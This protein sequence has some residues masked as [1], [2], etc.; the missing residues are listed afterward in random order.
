M[1]ALLPH[2]A[3]AATQAVREEYQTAILAVLRVLENAE[4][5]EVLRLLANKD[6]F[7]PDVLGLKP[8]VV[9]RIA[10]A[11]VD[12]CRRWEWV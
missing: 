5:K 6:V 10:E 9:A 7:I 3:G 8:A 12:V 1:A 11:V 4:R 2:F